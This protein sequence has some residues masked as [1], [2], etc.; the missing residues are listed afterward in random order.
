[1]DL[2]IVGIYCVVLAEGRGRGGASLPRLSLPDLQQ[3][4][5]FSCSAWGEESRR[6]RKQVF[7]N[8]WT[9]ND[10]Q[11]N[12]RGWKPLNNRG[13]SPQSLVRDAQIVRSKHFRRFTKYIA[14]AAQRIKKLQ[15]NC[16]TQLVHAVKYICSFLVFA[17]F[18]KNLTLFSFGLYGHYVTNCLLK[19]TMNS[20]LNN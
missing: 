18:R 10:K 20:N 12:G 19:M 11:T 2:L 15:K 8:K 16:N 9:I 5:F 17:K 7:A 4:N 14:L 3:I 13:A 1:M 6:G